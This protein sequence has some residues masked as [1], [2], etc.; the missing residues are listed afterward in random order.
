MAD[1][2]SL[3]DDIL[4]KEEEIKKLRADDAPQSEID[5]LSRQLLRAKA[6]YKKQTGRPFTSVPPTEEIATV[7][8]IPTAADT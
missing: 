8:P 2:Q 4:A 3:K 6:T 5:D 1:E 7:P